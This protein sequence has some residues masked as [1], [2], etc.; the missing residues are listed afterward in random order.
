MATVPRLAIAA[1]L[2]V[3]LLAVAWA[4]PHVRHRVIHAITYDDGTPGPSVRFPDVKR[5][6]A[7]QPLVPADRVRVVLVDGLAEANT[8]DLPA[9]RE[10]CDRGLALEIDVGFPTVSLPVEVALWSGLTQQQTG[11]L[12]RSDH[13]LVPPL[14]GGIPSKV[15]GSR[16]VAEDHG[17]IVRSLGF[18]DARPPAER[19]DPVQDAD[20]VAWR[21]VWL[22]RA[23]EAVASDARLVFVHVLRVDTMG[24]RAGRASPLYAATAGQADAIVGELVAM[25]P[26][27]RWFLLSDHGHL[28]DG[29]HGGEE[30]E[31]RRVEGCIAG[32]GVAH[33][34]ARGRGGP[35]H[36]VDVARAIA[37]SVGVTLD[38]RSP[39]RPLPTALAAPF[40]GDQAVPALPLTTGALVIFLIVA[41]AAASYVAAGRWWL[42]P[43]WFPVACA[44]LALVRGLPTLSMTMV[45]APAGRAMYV[46]WL[47]SLVLA[48]IATYFGL[49]RTSLPRALIAQL[50]LPVAAL[51]AVITACGAW[52]TIFGASI[53]PVVPHYTAWLSALLLLSAHGA[54][55]VAL[56]IVAR[57]VRTLRVPAAA[58]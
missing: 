47:P 49:A 40:D 10:L 28:D 37:D 14:A 19:D 5:T 29:G 35:I 23:R 24:H 39:A 30:R 8:R 41:G 51:A 13:P 21:E 4:L 22:A 57:C 50:A 20:P 33:P 26:D 6:P 2:A 1:V 11:V 42:W 48:A 25:S 17:W 45:Y 55:A 27:A 32:P 34:S 18:A 7:M 36:I 43:W 46:T 15:P 3:V 44:S 54:A 52:R 38:A 16:A 56:G 9:W 53:A 12:M 58:A 31:L